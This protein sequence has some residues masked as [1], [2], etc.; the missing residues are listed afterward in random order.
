VSDLWPFSVHSLYIPDNCDARQIESL[1]KARLIHGEVYIGEQSPYLL[2]TPHQHPNLSVQG[3]NRPPKHKWLAIPQ[4]Y[5][6][7][8]VLSP[9]LDQH[10]FVLIHS[11]KGQ[12]YW[13]CKSKDF[14]QFC[15]DQDA[16]W[17]NEQ[18]LTSAAQ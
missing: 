12:L 6:M 16:Q 18:E 3:L 8:C 1:S 5:S 11:G 17:Q 15:L 14:I 10:E 4:Q 13:R 9:Y 7:P 2:V